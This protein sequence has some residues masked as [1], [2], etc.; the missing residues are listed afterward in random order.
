MT[1]IT[2]PSCASHSASIASSR[3]CGRWLPPR[4]AVDPRRACGRY[5][6]VVRALTRLTCLALLPCVLYAQPAK[7]R[8]A[9]ENEALVFDGRIEPVSVARALDLLQ[10]PGITRLVITS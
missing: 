4:A 3:R 10:Q 1:S 5:A 7:T 9:R 8:V 2:T 6:G